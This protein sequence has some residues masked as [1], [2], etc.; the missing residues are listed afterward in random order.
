MKHYSTPGTPRFKIVRPNDEID[1]VN[2]MMQS[3]YR[4][5]VGMF[6]YLIKHSRPD[7]ADVVRKLSSV[8]TGQQWL[9]TRKC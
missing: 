8:W 7:I 2:A 6:L 9:H 5:G 4:S 1:G 3:R